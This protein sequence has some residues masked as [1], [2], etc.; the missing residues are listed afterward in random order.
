[1][2]CHKLLISDTENLLN[3]EN[4]STEQRTTV[5][6]LYRSLKKEGSH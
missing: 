1:M 6:K 2:S 5:I 4:L 3:L